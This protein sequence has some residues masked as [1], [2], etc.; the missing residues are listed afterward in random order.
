MNLKKLLLVTSCLFLLGGCG[1]GEGSSEPENHLGFDVT[2]GEYIGFE[3]TIFTFDNDEEIVK[4][5]YYE[6]YEKYLKKQDASSR[7]HKFSFEPLYYFQGFNEVEY[8]TAIVVHE[9]EM[10]YKFFY[11]K[12]KNFENFNFM[13]S[14]GKEYDSDPSCCSLVPMAEASL[15]GLKDI[16]NGKYKSSVATKYSEDGKSWSNVSYYIAATVEDLK[17][18]VTRFQDVYHTP[19]VICEN[20]AIDLFD[21]DRIYTSNEGLYLSDFN[22]TTK[23]FKLFQANK[24]D[25]HGFNTVEMWPQ[26]G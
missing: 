13:A 11:A 5:D 20:E 21:W 15:V 3:N 26:M 25:G 17:I 9:G 23:T 4:I 8:E 7:T 19:I 12:S 1:S 6:T 22:P 14:Y 10:V 18:T 16:P 24:T 2:S